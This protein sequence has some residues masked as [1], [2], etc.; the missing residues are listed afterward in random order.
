MDEPLRIVIVGGVAGGASA[1]ARARRL[2]ETAEIVVFERGPH[3][4]FA[5]C[6][7]PYHVGGVIADRKRL[8]V[9]TPREP[10]G[11]VRP[12]RAR[13]H[14]GAAASTAR[15]RRSSSASAR[16]A[17]STASPTTRSSSARVPSR[18]ARR[19]RASTTRASSRCGTWRTWT[20]SSRR[21]AAASGP[22]LVVGGG[23]IGLEMAEALRQ[24]GARRRAR[25]APAAGDGR[26][27]PRR[28]WRRSTTSC[29]RTASTCGW[30]T[31]SRPSSRPGGR[32]RGAALGRLARLLRPRP[33]RRGRPAR[34]E[35]RPRGGPRARPDRR[36]PGRRAHAHERPGDL[37]GRRRGRGARTSS[38]RRAALI[39]LA[40]PANR[41]GRIAA[42]NIFGR[43]SRY[44]AT[45]G[46]AICKVFDL[47]FAMTGASETALKRAGRPYRRVYVH[48]ADHATLLPR[49]AADQPEAA[50]RSGRR[51]GSSAR[52]PWARAAS[53]SGST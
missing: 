15:R 49:R 38:A 19:S 17:A 45:Q 8:L 35:A 52:R 36:H 47:A 40:G 39:P 30:A 13:E 33:P 41:Q 12:R 27:R 20:A 31:R 44:A 4:S 16:P 24:R 11:A 37:G 18:S 5:N 7:L 50:L 21:L 14:R 46:T 25:R 3:V 53:T 48:P 1:A 23:Y 43:D 51:A 26:R 34:D 28:W 42:D 10:P 32:P 9:Q 6:G 29:A 22:A 2:S